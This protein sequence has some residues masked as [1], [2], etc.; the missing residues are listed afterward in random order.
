MSYGQNNSDNGM[1]LLLQKHLKEFNANLG[2]RLAK[3]EQIMKIR[4]GGEG[5]AFGKSPE[6]DKALE[7]PSDWKLYIGDV[8]VLSPSALAALGALGVVQTSYIP[9]T[10]DLNDYKTTGIYRISSTLPTNAP[11][12]SA[13]SVLVVFIVGTTY[14]QV[15]INGSKIWTRSGNTSAWYSWYKFDGTAV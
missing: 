1:L 15:L 14:M 4:A 7:L 6:H 13:W 12:G 11:S 3:I 9:S 10:D 5:V 2:V 8:D